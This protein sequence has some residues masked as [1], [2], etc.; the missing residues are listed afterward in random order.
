MGSQELLLNSASLVYDK[1][2]IITPK[3][4]NRNEVLPICI[5]LL[6]NNDLGKCEE[7]LDILTFDKESKE[8]II[9]NK[10]L[11]IFKEF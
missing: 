7:W 8:I 6:I 4:I 1:A 3:Q 9:K 10:I 5:I 2:K 11:S